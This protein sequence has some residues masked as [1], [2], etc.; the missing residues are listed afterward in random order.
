MINLSLSTASL[1][2]HSYESK[3]IES[4]FVEIINKKSNH[5][6]GVVYRHPTSC[7][8]NF[9]IL[10]QTYFINW[11][12]KVA[13]TYLSLVTSTSTCY[14]IQITN[15][16]LI[17]MISFH[18]NFFYQPYICQQKSAKNLILQL[19]TVSQTTTTLTPLAET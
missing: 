13:K 17:F 3:Y 12:K 4:F 8:N 2:Y 19:I 14:T 9:Q 11:K 10:F 18:R 5:I 16:Q 15:I 6:V 7:E 1:R